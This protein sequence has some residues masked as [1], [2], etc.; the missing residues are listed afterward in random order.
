MER[1]GQQRRPLAI[2]LVPSWLKRSLTESDQNSEL[3]ALL[4]CRSSNMTCVGRGRI[5]NVLS[6]HW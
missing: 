4:T 5:L 3:L 1:V 2:R 6:W